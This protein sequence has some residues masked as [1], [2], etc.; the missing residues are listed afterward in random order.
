MHFRSPFLYLLLLINCLGLKANAQVDSLLVIYEKATEDTT[1][2]DL[3]LEMGLAILPE[4]PDSGLYYANEAE[5]LAK[6]IKDPYKADQVYRLKAFCYGDLNDRIHCLENHMMRVQILEATGEESRQLASV[7]F[8]IAAVFG[9]H[10]QSST[11]E[12]YYT[13]CKDLAIKLELKSHYGMSLVNMSEFKIQRGDIAGAKND[14]KTACAILNPDYSIYAAYAYSQLANLYLNEDSLE[15][16][17]NTVDA[18]LKIVED[19]GSEV[20][21][22]LYDSKGKVAYKRGKFKDAIGHYTAA[23]INWEGLNKFFYL[24]GLYLDL[25]YAYAELGSDSSIYFFKKHNEIRDQ[26]IN[27]E[28]N[29][30]IAEMEAK[31]NSVQKEKEIA[32]LEKE[33]EL[34]ELDARRS[35]QIS[36]IALSGLGLVFGLMVFLA[37]RVRIIRKQKSLIEQRNEEITIQKEIV[38]EKSKELTDSIMY[39]K[40]IQ[41]AI[42]PSKKKVDENLPENFIFYR[43][44]DIVAGDFYWLHP[45]ENGVLF[46]A[47]DCT[48]HGVPGAMVSVICNNGL[49][50]SVREH[51]LTN[52]ADILNK[53]REIVLEEFE[54]S[55]DEV[56]DGMDIALVSLELRASA[57]SKNETPDSH[58][59]LKFAGAHN[60]LW[61]VRVGSVEI[62]EYKADKQPIGRYADS[63]PFNLHQIELNPGDSFYI[64]SDGYADQFGGDKGKKFKAYNL[65]KLLLEIKDLSMSDQM[66]RIEQMFEEW[67]GGL[68]QLDDVCIIGVRV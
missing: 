26:A 22:F 30:A 61:I 25:A 41:N 31:F 49:N 57:D 44:K 33:N 67:K 1:K 11:A 65:K 23:R 5:K 36:W 4:S 63:K 19:P 32:L 54:K 64:F 8:E 43:P 66:T 51:N 13:M 18:G 6:K 37:S 14:L 45:I 10:G 29:S 59:I 42:L 68:E 35:S 12:K 28:N 20:V 60:P 48:G 58:S 47:A 27:E 50:R 56:K 2:L 21:G 3:L 15:L 55:E 46:A 34:S 24:Q 52:P 16:A 38:E 39:A 40:R 17:E 9:S 53:T 62:E 7:Y